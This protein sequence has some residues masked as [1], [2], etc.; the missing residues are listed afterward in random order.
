[1]GIYRPFIGGVRSLQEFEEKD[2]SND[3]PFTPGDAMTYSRPPL[4][5]LTGA[6]LLRGEKPTAVWN[7]ATP[8][9]TLTMAT[10]ME[11]QVCRLIDKFWPDSGLGSTEHGARNDPIADTMALIEIGG[12]I[13]KAPRV[14]PAAKMAT[15]A[16]FGAEGYKTQWALRR[17]AAFKARTGEQ[18]IL[19]T[20]LEGK[21]AMAEKMTTLILA[22]AT[23][24]TDNPLLRTAL[25]AGAMTFAGIGTARGERARQAYEPLIEDMLAHH[26]ERMEL[27]PTRIEKLGEK[28]LDWLA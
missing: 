8:W 18:L 25:S 21:E 5:A 12:A 23:H 7:A 9:A 3:K 2:H 22:T 1:M 24:D 6:I 15:A 14:T 16:V 28:A 19:P 26:A 10:D 4:A 20:S 11:G 13:L 17:N 27:M